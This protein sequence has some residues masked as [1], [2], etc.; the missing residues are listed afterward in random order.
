MAFSCEDR[1]DK[2]LC[3]KMEVLR[4]VEPLFV[5]LRMLPIPGGGG[6]GEGGGSAFRGIQVNAEYIVAIIISVILIILLPL[7]FFMKTV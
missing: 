7:L 1:G 2:T 4:S 6:Q 3:E 5:A